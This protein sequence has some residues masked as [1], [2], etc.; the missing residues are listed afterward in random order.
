MTPLFKKLNFKNHAQIV[1]LNLPPT[2]EAEVD[3][4]TKFA[5]VKKD[6]D[7][8]TG[9]NFCIAF[10]T[11]QN[12]LDAFADQLQDLLKGDPILW[13]CYPKATS[14]NY[15]CDFNRDNG[16]E[17]IANTLNMEPVRQI[18]IDDDWSAL[19]FRKVAFIKTI[20]R[21]ESFA[22][23]DDAKKKTNKKGE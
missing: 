15:K 22:L 8:I 2:L 13:V 5:E 14:K 10:A 20:T 6:L 11:Q 16:W 19:R 23:T 12:Q 7:N 18:A 4:M 21:R 3:E 1:V 9:L 17:Y